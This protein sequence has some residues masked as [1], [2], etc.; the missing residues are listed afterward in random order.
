MK[1]VKKL[2]VVTVL[3]LGLM[4]RSV[5]AETEIVWWHSMDGALNDWVNDLAAEFNERQTA[6]KV[7][8]VFKGNYEQSM[9][10]GVA[11]YRAGEAPDILQVFEVGTASMIYAD[12]VTK[13]VTEIMKENDIP[14]DID[15]YI[16]AVASYY[17]APTGELLSLPFNSSTTVMYYNKDAFSK[18]GLDPENAPKTWEDIRVATEALKASGSSCP[19]TTTWMGWTQLE[20]FSSWHNTPVATQNNGFDGLGV[21]LLMNK[22]LQVR[23][24]NNLSDMAKDGLFVYKGRA[25]AGSPAFISGECAIMFG[26]SGSYGTIARDAKFKFGEST[27]PYYADVEGAPQNTVIGGASLWVMSGKP[28]E[29]YKGVAEFFEYISQPEVQSKSHMRTGYLPVTKE[30]F[31]L[32]EKAGF[33]DENP[34]A[35]V[36]VEQMIRK[37][38]DNTRGIRLGNMLQIRSIIDEETESIWTGDKTAEEALDNVVERGNKL[39]ERFERVNSK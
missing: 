2:A 23:H 18:A 17:T 3:G 26:S 6:Y 31:E 9:T 36:P 30:A 28:A 11:A 32:T 34:G 24:M 37:A 19:M 16:P 15:A 1:K 35:D 8:P 7:V 27:L 12:G 33:Y 22:P 10:A 38:T 39:L 29:N 25:D 21:E 4:S 5:M 20:S 14:F 13:S